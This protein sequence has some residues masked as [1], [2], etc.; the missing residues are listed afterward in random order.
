MS[1]TPRSTLAVAALAFAL[2]APSEAAAQSMDA[3]AR[4]ERMC[5]IRAEKFDLVLPR[6]M[7]DNDLDMWI[8]V[9]R[10]GLLDPMW[11]ALGRGYVGD[12]GYWVFTDRGDRTERAVLGVGGYRLERCDVYDYF[13]S[14]GE[15]AEYVAERDPRGSMRNLDFW[16]RS[17]SA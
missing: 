8:V 11:E 7:H 4:W 17:G 14:A 5:Q 9:M 16:I 15:L 12:W 1:P 13:G 6:A 10:E 3:R 2:L